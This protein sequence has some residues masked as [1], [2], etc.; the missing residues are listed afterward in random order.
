MGDALQVAQEKNVE[1]MDVV[2][3][4]ETVRATIIVRTANV[5]VFQI[6]QEE[7]ADQMDVQ[8]S[9]ALARRDSFAEQ[10]VY[11]FVHRIVKVDNVDRT[12]VEDIVVSVMEEFPIVMIMVFV[13][14]F[15]FPIA[16]EDNVELTGVELLVVNALQGT[17]A[18]VLVFATTNAFRIV[19][20]ETVEMTVVVVLV[21]LVLKELSVT[22]SEDVKIIVF[23]HV[24]EKLAVLMDVGVLVE[25]VRTVSAV[26]PTELVAQHVEINTVIFELKMLESAPKIVLDAVTRFAMSE[27]PF[28]HALLTV[29]SFVEMATVRRVKQPTIAHLIA[30]VFVAMVFV[31]QLSSKL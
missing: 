11:V 16:W 9:V 24:Q 1:L 14:P 17:F 31:K 29:L 10:T 6:V 28:L 13:P 27:K 8:V 7:I 26:L 3:L 5:F 18:T 12:D 20:D 23:L 15:V 30:E 2:V 25:H 19:M 22:H 21:E 4:A